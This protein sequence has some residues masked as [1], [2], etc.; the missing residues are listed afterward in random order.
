MTT[1]DVSAALPFETAPETAAAKHWAA[2]AQK[3][4]RLTGLL[5]L[6]TYV[7]SIPPVLWFYAP[8]LGDPAYVGTAGSNIGLRAFRTS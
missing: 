1:L 8:V 5:F 6:V 4:G 3:L 7:T 2:N